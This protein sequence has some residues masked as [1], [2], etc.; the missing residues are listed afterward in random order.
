MPEAGK[1][2]CANAQCKAQ[3]ETVKLCKGITAKAAKC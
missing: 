3:F 2:I 1:T